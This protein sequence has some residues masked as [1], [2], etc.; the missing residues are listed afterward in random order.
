[1]SIS[2]LFG[3]VSVALLS[4]SLLVLI[5]T[6]FLPPDMRKKVLRHLARKWII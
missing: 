4:L 3:I 6:V 5:L 2:D 1:M